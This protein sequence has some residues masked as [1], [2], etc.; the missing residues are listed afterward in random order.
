MNSFNK[1]ILFWWA[2]PT[3]SVDVLYFSLTIHFRQ[4]TL[5]S[6]VNWFDNFDKIFHVRWFVLT[7]RPISQRRI[8]STTSTVNSSYLSSTAWLIFLRR[9]N[10]ITSTV[11]I[12]SAISTDRTPTKCLSLKV[13]VCSELSQQETTWTEQLRWWHIFNR[14]ALEK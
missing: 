7:N 8:V 14:T 2:V 4:V 9:A 12:I 1:P 13:N 10:S 6:T 11:W 3:T 5:P